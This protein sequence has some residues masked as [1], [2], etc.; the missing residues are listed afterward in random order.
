[1]RSGAY[2]I[3]PR[4]VVAGSA[5][6]C[7]VELDLDLEANNVGNELNVDLLLP[8]RVWVGF[9]FVFFFY[10]CLW[11]WLWLWLRL[12]FGPCR[13]PWVFAFRLYYFLPFFSF[14]FSLRLQLELVA[15]L[16]IKAGIPINMPVLGPDKGNLI[17]F[18]NTNNG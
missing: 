7:P 6:V 15:L 3:P 13:I 2:H 4:L 5:L 11:L 14:F 16:F 10:L 8:L 18:C 1:M 12:L 17:L 9:T